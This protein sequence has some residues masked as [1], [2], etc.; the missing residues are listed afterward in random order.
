M[1]RRA[2]KPD[3]CEAIGGAEVGEVEVESPAMV[4]MWNVVC[5]AE[6]LFRQ[7]PVPL[8]RRRL[9]FVR[10]VQTTDDLAELPSSIS[11][12]YGP[13]EQIRAVRNVPNPVASDGP[14]FDLQ[15]VL[16]ARQETPGYS[17]LEIT[18][19]TGR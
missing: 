1:R 3:C 18:L 4:V 15:R 14:T 8:G 11:G 12:R 19:A 9:G 16:P 7:H 5:W 13:A 10:Q 6:A 2:L 17:M